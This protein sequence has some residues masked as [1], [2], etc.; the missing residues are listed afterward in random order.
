MVEKRYFFKEKT[1]IK[2]IP[3]Y[4]KWSPHTRSQQNG[5]LTSLEL[6]T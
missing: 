3:Q 6:K 1:R 4:R 5:H 2:Y